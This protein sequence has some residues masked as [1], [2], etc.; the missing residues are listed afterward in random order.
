VINLN[1]LN[2]LI[3]VPGAAAAAAANPLLTG[4]LAY[5]KFESDGTDSHDNGYDLTPENSPTIVTGESGNAMR[6]S[7][8]KFAHNS[9]LDLGGLDEVTMMCFFNAQAADLN[10]II[11][12]WNTG[13]YASFSDSPYAIQVQASVIKVH[14]ITDSAYRS[15]VWTTTTAVDGSQTYHMRLKFDMA[16]S[17]DVNKIRLYI[18]GTDKG[19]A[20]V[21]G[22]LGSEI[23]Q[24]GPAYP[25]Y[26]FQLGA[27]DTG[28]QYYTGFLDEVGI[29]NKLVSDEDADLH[30][31]KTGLPY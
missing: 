8:T 4:L 13:G 10:T 23:T 19:D 29:W 6:F 2:V 1:P 24:F 27:L 11:C 25:N 5:Y 16:Q 22:A 28:S 26:R 30:R 17:L 31:L 12:Q 3:S 14:I 18:D 15:V 21:S 7:Y 20:V 9:D